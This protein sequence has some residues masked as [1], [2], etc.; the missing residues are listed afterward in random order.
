MPELPE[1]ET[2]VR[3]LAPTLR[4]RRIAAVWIG[5]P[6]A[7]DPRGRPAETIVGETI[8]DVRRLG[9][10]IVL[11]LSGGRHATI[12]LRM[13]GRLILDPL[14]NLPHARLIFTFI[15][16]SRLVLSDARKFGRLRIVD[17]DLGAALAQGADP[18]DKSLTA[19]ALAKMLKGRRTPIKVWL[20]NQRY[21]AGIGNIYAC[22][23][24]YEAGIRP[25]KRAGRLTSMQRDRLLHR[26]RRVLRNAIRNRGSSVDDYLDAEGKPGGFQNLLAVYGR[27]GLPCRRCGTP[28]RR[29]VQAQRGTFFCPVC[30]R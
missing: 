30:Q 16:G 23:S 21:L 27:S 19:Q 10:F 20:T 28:I 7:V 24:L 3:D 13:T 1:V 29:I 25:T 6:R 15:G 11:Q 18:F 5:W 9:K 12:H 2:I 22:E 26:M 14:D 17:G 8:L 4:G